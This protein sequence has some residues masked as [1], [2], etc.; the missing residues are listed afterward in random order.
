MPTTMKSWVITRAPMWCS[1]ISNINHLATLLFCSVVATRI[2]SPGPGSHYVK[3]Y[4]NRK[5]VPPQSTLTNEV[6]TFRGARLY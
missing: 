5:K 2:P 4:T 3:C 1:D 6:N